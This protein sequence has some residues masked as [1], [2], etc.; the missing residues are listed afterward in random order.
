MTR[1][2]ILL[3]GLIL[4]ATRLAQEY[5]TIEGPNAWGLLPGAGSSAA[6]WNNARS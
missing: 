6:R 5:L 2:L 1:N 3:I 4:P